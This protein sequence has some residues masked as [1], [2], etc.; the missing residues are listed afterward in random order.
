MDDP[1]AQA[2]G[3]HCQSL[4]VKIGD[5]LDIGDSVA[6]ASAA[7]EIGDII[8]K[9]AIRVYA[10]QDLV[11]DLLPADGEIRE[12]YVELLATSILPTEE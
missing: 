8:G 7:H 9:L 10:L 5:S 2:I 11:R 4:M 12:A 6:A 1:R 3:E